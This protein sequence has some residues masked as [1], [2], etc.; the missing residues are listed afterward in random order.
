MITGAIY[1]TP[2]QSGDRQRTG[3]PNESDKVPIIYAR[4]VGPCIQYS[5]SSCPNGAPKALLKEVC[6]VMS[7][8]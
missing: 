7:L 6:H 2:L 8:M 4:I 1:F 5:R 3:A